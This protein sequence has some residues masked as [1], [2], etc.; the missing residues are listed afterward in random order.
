MNTYT[1]SGRSASD[2]NDQ[3]LSNNFGNYQRFQRESSLVVSAA[4]SQKY[5]SLKLG[6]KTPKIPLFHENKYN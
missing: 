5:L 3:V 4:N 2:Q 1:P 6:S